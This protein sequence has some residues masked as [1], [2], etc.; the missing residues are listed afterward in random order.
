MQIIDSN[1]NN[2]ISGGGSYVVIQGGTNNL[3][4]NDNDPNTV[5]RAAIE[6]M[7]AKALAASMTP[8]LVNI[9]PLG[10]ASSWTVAKQ[11]NLESYNTWITNYATTNG[12]QMADVYS[13]LTDG[14]DNLKTEYNSGDGVHLSDLGYRVMGAKIATSIITAGPW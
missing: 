6:S 9:T 2:A 13:S 4:P 14:S 8:I 7:V 1:F 3:T 5:M 10:S 11:T 12:Y